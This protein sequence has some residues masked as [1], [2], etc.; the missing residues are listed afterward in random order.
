MKTSSKGLNLIKQFEGCRLTSYKCPAGVWT[1]GYG[2]TSG[3][4][5]G[6]S[7]AQEQAEIYLKEDLSRFEHYV[8]AYTSKYGY[9]INQD[10]FDA[11]V[12]F[13]YNAGP[14]NLDRQLLQKGKRPLELVKL[15]LPTTCIKARGKVLQGLVRRR[16]AEAD[17]MGDCKK[18]IAVVAKEV[19]DGCWGNG[20]ARKR[21]LEECGYNP[22]EIQDEVNKLML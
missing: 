9:E 19:M 1:I 5:E 6:Q 2:H 4:T 8:N 13:A 18:S 15:Y 17:L 10:Q 12:S 21:Q 20:Q 7:I 11:L 22:K 3:V 16:V 14:G